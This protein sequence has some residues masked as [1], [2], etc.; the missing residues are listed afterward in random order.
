MLS[1]ITHSP[2]AIAVF[3]LVH[4]AALI[5]T[6]HAIC[7]KRDARS[8]ASWVILIVFVPLVGALLY[9]W[10]GINRVRRRAR[11]LRARRTKRP[12]RAGEAHP[13]HAHPALAL[14]ARLNRDPL[15]TGNRLTMLVNGEEA[16][17]DMLRSIREAKASISLA[18]YI[19]D[20]DSAGHEFAQALNEA[21]ARGVQVRVLVDAVG[22][23]YSFPS[24]FRRLRSA[25][26]NLRAARFLDT[27]LPW[28]YH[29]SQLRNHRKILV[30]DG[31]VAY[32]GGMNIRAG[33][34][35]SRGGPDAT[36]DLHFR[37]EGPVVADVQD[38]FAADWEFTTRETLGG[39]A[40]FPESLPA[41]GETFARIVSD[42]PDEDFEKLRW[43]IL[44][45]ISVARESVR[46]LTPY[47]VPDQALIDSLGLAAL[48]GVRVEIVLPSHNNVALVHWASRALLWQLLERGCRIYSAPAPFD[49][50]KLFLVDDT[51][52]LVGSANWDARSLRL[53]FELGL[54]VDDPALS[55]ELVAQFE[56]KRR[57]ARE[58]SLAEVDA[59][60]I[61]A[62]LRDGT[63]RLFSP[64]L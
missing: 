37:V 52:A 21:A 34:L 8:A 7:Y 2:S 3:L 63:A 47:F 51:W 23:R 56:K 46:I 15:R 30:A 62:R 19:F 35:V 13:S 41:R 57:Q 59:R 39:G 22:A 43:T 44:G 6:G 58:V 33:H 26:G 60:S 49:H 53:N 14:S 36:Q 31:R 61:L 28:R 20:N 45:A 5:A 18:T 27:V 64:Y 11:G 17:P 24:I 55:A 16:Y 1:H 40:W 29:Y 9:F 32:L 42:G 10:I 25:G 48:R 4:L 12:H 38:V 50:S 54:E